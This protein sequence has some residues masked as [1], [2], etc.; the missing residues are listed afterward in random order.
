ML[1]RLT[2]VL[3]LAG[4]GLA[5]WG[6]QES[7]ACSVAGPPPP[8]RERLAAAAGAFV[9]TV[10]SRSDTPPGPGGAVGSGDP[11]VLR[12]AVERAYKGD[13]GSEVDVMTVRSGATCGLAAQPGDRLALLLRTD[14]QGRWT[15][16]LGDNVDPAEL[17]NAA[18]TLAAGGP[19]RARLTLHAV[20]ARNLRVRVTANRAGTATLIARVA[21]LRIRRTLR[22]DAPG[23]RTA[24]LIPVTRSDRRRLAAARRRP[25]R[26]HATIAATMAGAR[27][28]TRTTLA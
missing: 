26:L 21:G 17:E 5:T 11:T 10:I 16:G 15:A 14:A 22:F 8:L 28:S 6:A 2:L 25:G 20:R 12:F 4:L 18:R 24:R 7:V 1:Q 27:A 3:V 13:L 23:T 9:G 19:T